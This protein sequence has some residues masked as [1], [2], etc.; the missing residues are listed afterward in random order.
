S[1]VINEI[2]F[3]P[4]VTNASYIEIFNRSTTTTFDLWNYRVNG[5]SFHFNPGDVIAPQAYMVLVEDPIAFQ[6][7]YGT[8]TLIAGVFDGKLDGNGET[9]SLVK[10]ALTTNETDVVIDKVKY[11]VVPPWPAAP[12]ATNSGV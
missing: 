3:R 11:E 5:L 4:A 2:M 8:N 7:A 9:L 1:L 10:E 6:A 12:G